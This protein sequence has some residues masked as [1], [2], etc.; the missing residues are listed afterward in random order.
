M[1]GGTDGGREEGK[2]EKGQQKKDLGFTK[3]ISDERKKQIPICKVENVQT[4]EWCIQLE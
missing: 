2:G 4:E 1:D 3:R